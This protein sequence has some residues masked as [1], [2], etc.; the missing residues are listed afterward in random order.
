MGVG[1]HFKAP[2]TD[3]RV[4]AD[5]RHTEGLL[6]CRTLYL[7][8]FPSNLSAIV[9]DVGIMGRAWHSEPHA[10]VGRQAAGADGSARVPL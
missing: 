8:N 10:E 1:T 7:K 3:K 6:V 9:L 2:H 4:C 5:I